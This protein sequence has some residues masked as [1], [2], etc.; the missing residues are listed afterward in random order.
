MT[1]WLNANQQRNWRSFLA[2]VVVLPDLFSKDLQDCRELTLSDYEI[3]VRL[4]EAP[5][6]CIRMSDLAERVMSSRSRLTHQIDRMIAA[7][8]VERTMCEEDKRGFNAV[9]TDF[10]YEK[11]VAAAP[12]HVES[13]RKHLVDVL[14][15]EEFEKLGQISRKIFAALDPQMQR[16]IMDGLPDDEK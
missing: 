2:I 11:L 4:S 9:L 1:R 12:D 3:L 5:N 10:G 15:D 6:R 13:V 14:S 7:G 8:L 16:K